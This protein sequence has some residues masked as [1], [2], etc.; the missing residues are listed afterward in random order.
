MKLN[1]NESKIW[2]SS[3]LHL[4]HT[5]ICKGVSKWENKE[6]CRPFNTIDEMNTCII[7]NINSLVEQNDYLFLLG[8]TLMG[9]KNY[10]SFLKRITCKNVFLLRGN[11]CNKNKLQNITNYLGDYIELYINKQ[12]VICSHYP[13]L[14][15]RDMNK[16]S[17]MLYGHCHGGISKSKHLVAKY[18]NN[19]KTL[20]VGI[21]NAYRIY[22]DYIPF[23]YSDILNILKLNNNLAIDHH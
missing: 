9:K 17:I 14:S 16:G 8:D 3:D 19:L 13:L 10:I 7:N 22:G 18:Y 1:I 12:L 2:F 6:N 15:F 5:N 4:G 20:D 21:D 11:H 23:N